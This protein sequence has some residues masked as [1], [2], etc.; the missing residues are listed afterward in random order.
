MNHN[1][2]EF[3]NLFYTEFIKQSWNVKTLRKKIEKEDMSTY[4][5]TS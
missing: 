1:Y 4:C 2:T 5:Q 3:I